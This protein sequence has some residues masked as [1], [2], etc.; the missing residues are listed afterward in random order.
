MAEARIDDD[1]FSSAPVI[2]IEASGPDGEP[3]QALW[4]RVGP[5]YYGESEPRELGVWIS[6][7]EWHMASGL[8][9]PVLLPPDVWD[10]LAAA[11]ARRLRSKRHAPWWRR[12]FRSLRRR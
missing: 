7:Q 3:G 4:I 9:G 10:E 5:V 2:A 6:Y 11:V 8:Q 1:G 12:A